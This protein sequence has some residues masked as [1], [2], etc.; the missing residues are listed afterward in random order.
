MNIREIEQ[1]DIQDILDIRVA[2]K[3]NHFSMQDLAD[4][5]ITSQSVSKWLDGSIKGWICEISNKPVGFAMGDGDT[6]EVLVIAIYPQY[7]KQGLGKKLMFRLQNW[8]FASG[9]KKLWLWS[10]PSNKVRAYGFYR[11]LGWQPTGEI[12]GNDELL[13]LKKENSSPSIDKDNG[14]VVDSPDQPRY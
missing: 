5:G 2:T 13:T 11:K 14:G 6:G 3:E 4:I 12:K 8:L 10:N 7:E 1:S 9:H